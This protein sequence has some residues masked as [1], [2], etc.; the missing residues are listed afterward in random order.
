LKGISVRGKYE[1]AACG[2]ILLSYKIPPFSHP[3]VGPKIILRT[4]CLSGSFR[5]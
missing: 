3:K 4:D 2:I 5:K 1:A